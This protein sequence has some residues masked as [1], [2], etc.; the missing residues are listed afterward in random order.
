M[1]RQVITTPN[2]P[3]SPLQARGSGPILRARLGNDR[4]RCDTGALAGSI[5]QDQTRQSLANCEAMKRPGAP[6]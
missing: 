4:R 3:S 5:I 1:P 6:P 2:A